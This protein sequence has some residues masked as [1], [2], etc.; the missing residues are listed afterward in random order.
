MANRQPFRSG[1]SPHLI[2]V[3]EDD[4]AVRQTTA[5]VL[6][7]AGYTVRTVE[8]GGSVFEAVAARR[9]ALIL[10]DLSLPVLDGWQVLEQL[11]AQGNAPPVV[12]MTAHS[13][14]AGRALEAGA[15]A[16]ILKPFNIDE[17]ISVVHRVLETPRSA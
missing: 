4:E 2:L 16:A 15:A 6:E 5:D 11:Q 10:L 1:S 14:M 12:M 13:H 3:V 8:D 17:L 7:D 9:P